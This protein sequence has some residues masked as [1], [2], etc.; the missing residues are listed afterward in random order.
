MKETESKKPT[1]YGTLTASR[2]AACVPCRLALFMSA[3]TQ[4][5]SARV[6]D[7]GSLSRREMISK[8]VALDCRPR[9]VK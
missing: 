7:N 1:T 8:V 9:K 4:V 2:S 6:Y 3:F 5:I